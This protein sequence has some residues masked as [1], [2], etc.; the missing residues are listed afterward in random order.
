MS[1]TINKH[2]VFVDQLA[3]R[4]QSRYDEVHTHLRLFS[5]RRS[6]R[7]VAAEIDLLGV[8][9]EQ[10]DIYEVK[11]S[12]RPIK[13]RKQ[14]RRIQRLLGKPDA[15]MFFFNGESGTITAVAGQD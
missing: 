14:L 9:G 12:H 5:H 11:C 4:L 3:H 1:E 15:G 2:D 7:H 10:M 8:R 13:A 6:K